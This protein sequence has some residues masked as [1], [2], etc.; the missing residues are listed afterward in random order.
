[1]AALLAVISSVVKSAEFFCRASLC[2]PQLLF[3]VAAINKPCFSSLFLAESIPLRLACLGGIK[4]KQ[5]LCM[6]PQ[7]SGESGHSSCSSFPG[8]G[9]SFYL[10]SYLMVLNNSGLGDGPMQ[11]KWSC[12]PSL[13]F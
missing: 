3:C 8:E 2:E 11:A 4:P 13:F 7:K 6:V 5:K 12:L 9:L 1:M 10:G